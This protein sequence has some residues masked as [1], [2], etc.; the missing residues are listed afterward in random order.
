VDQPDAGLLGDPGLGE[1]NDWLGKLGDWLPDG[2]TAARAAAA[3]FA[4]AVATAE[5]VALEDDCA[6]PGPVRRHI[7][8]LAD[9]ALR[10]M[11]SQLI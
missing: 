5:A 3:A 10:L 1:L 11:G 7:L 8:M 4:T 6:D 2:L 9:N